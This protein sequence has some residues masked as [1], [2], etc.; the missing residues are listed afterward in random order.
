MNHFAHH[1]ANEDLTGSRLFAFRRLPPAATTRAIDPLMIKV[2]LIAS[3]PPRKP[4][5]AV[6][7]N[8][9]MSGPKYPPRFPSELITAIPVAA[10][11]P[12]ILEV[13][14]AQN[15]PTIDSAKAK[16]TPIPA[17]TTIGVRP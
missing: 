2:A 16:P 5:F 7:K 14:M 6:R 9:M 11:N 15:G 8:P 13:A 3:R 10:D 1:P 12:A 17:T 4:P